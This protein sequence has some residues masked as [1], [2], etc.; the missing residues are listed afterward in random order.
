[1]EKVMQTRY[2]KVG[3][4]AAASGLSESRIRALFDSGVLDGFHVGDMRL[5][6]S[7]SRERYVAARAGRPYV[8]VAELT[9]SGVEAQP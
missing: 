6:D 9:T 7:A 3:D 8:R 1:M 5:I 4:A 2:E